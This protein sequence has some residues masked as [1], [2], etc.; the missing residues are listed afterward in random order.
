MVEETQS[1]LEHQKCGNITQEHV[2]PSLNVNSGP[3][4]PPAHAE[5]INLTNRF[6]CSLRLRTI[7]TL[8]TWQKRRLRV[9]MNSQASAS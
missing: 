4:D 8:K 9:G 5:D 3:L 6:D 2:S 1:H 7:V